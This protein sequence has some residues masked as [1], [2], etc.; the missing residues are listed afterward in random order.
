M[1]KDNWQYKAKL[2][3]YWFTKRDFTEDKPLVT[4]SRM[5]VSVI[6]LNSREVVGLHDIYVAM[7]KALS[8]F[9][10]YSLV[11]HEKDPHAR[12]LRH[13][14]NL[15]LI[16]LSTMNKTPDPVYLAEMGRD[17]L[18]DVIDKCGVGGLKL[19]ASFDDARGCNYEF[20]VS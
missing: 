14:E 20:L 8:A 18:T 4:P 1:K 12:D 9:F 11:I 7:M 15:G 19:M 6:I 3:D 5:I 10:E 2:G 13:L 17:I 16:R